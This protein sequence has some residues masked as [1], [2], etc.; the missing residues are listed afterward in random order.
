[1]PTTRLVLAVPV[2]AAAAAVAGCGGSSRAA[3]PGGP[4]TAGPS[5]TPAASAAGASAA[6]VLPVALDEW[7]VRA[8]RARVAAGPV[9]LTVRNDGKTAHEL[10]VVRA[11]RSG[12]SLGTGTRVSEAGSVGEASDIAPGAEKTLTLTLTPGRYQLICNL[13]GHYKLGMHTE[14]TVA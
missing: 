4:P 7:S 11:P 14:L 1:M 3:G 13:P 10:I 8:D 12:A 5:S 6:A 9:R 2:L